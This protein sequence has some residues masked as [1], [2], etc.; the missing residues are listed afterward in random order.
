[1]S[2]LFTPE[3]EP[4]L[5]KIKSIVHSFFRGNGWQTGNQFVLIPTWFPPTYS[6]HNLTLTGLCDPVTVHI[7]E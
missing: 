4:F 3:S 6:R 1:M 7:L 2:R 5:R